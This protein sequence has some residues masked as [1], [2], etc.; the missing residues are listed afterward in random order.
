[1]S[2]GA[3]TRTSPAFHA[4]RRRSASPPLHALED[5]DALADSLLSLRCEIENLRGTSREEARSRSLRLR[6][7]REARIE[8]VLEEW[9][10]LPENMPPAPGGKEFLKVRGRVSGRGVGER[11]E[12]KREARRGSWERRT[13]EE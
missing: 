5:V 2:F 12:R 9:M 1:M 3:P 7:A 13:N 10:P 4:S 6:S 11:E 8:A